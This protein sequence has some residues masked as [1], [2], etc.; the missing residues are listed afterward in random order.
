MIIHSN[1]LNDKKQGQEIKGKEK[2]GQDK[3]QQNVRPAIK[4]AVRNPKGRLAREEKKIN[5][6][7]EDKRRSILSREEGIEFYP[8]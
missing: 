2:T 4:E 5:L 7:T 1:G 3:T 6:G 8:Q